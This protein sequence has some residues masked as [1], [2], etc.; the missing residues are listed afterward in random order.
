MA[1]FAILFGGIGA[2][3]LL[4]GGAYLNAYWTMR[5]TDTTEV[6]AVSGSADE[7]ELEGTARTAGETA[8][9]PLTGEDALVHEWEV[10]YRSGSGQ[11]RYWS[12]VESGSAATPFLLEDGSGQ[13][14]VD[15]AGA[16]WRL[17]EKTWTVDDGEEPPPTIRSYLEASDSDEAAASEVVHSER[18][19]RFTE[20]RLDPGEQVAVYGPVQAGPHDAA[21]DSAVGPYVATDEPV[22]DASA[23]DKADMVLHP[24]LL[25]GVGDPDDTLGVGGAGEGTV[26]SVADSSADSARK[27]FRNT[28]LLVSTAGVFFLAVGLGA[29]LF[30]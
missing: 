22:H 6:A 27:G 14:L 19:R 28:G 24:G 2:M 5:S 23:H 30:V 16:S 3:L 1:L 29:L 21:P 8:R 25:P 26:F 12:T 7:V 10:E 4:A 11:R 17:D 13:M 20:A 15:P 9:A 18:R